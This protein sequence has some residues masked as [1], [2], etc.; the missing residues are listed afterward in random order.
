[1]QAPN[2]NHFSRRKSFL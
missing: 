2:C 1:M